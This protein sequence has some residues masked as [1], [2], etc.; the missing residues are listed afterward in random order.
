M[1]KY[2]SVD[3]LLMQEIDF[4]K[5]SAKLVKVNLAKNTILGS[6]RPI[7]ILSEQ[8]F[9]LPEPEVN[10]D[11]SGYESGGDDVESSDECFW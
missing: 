11:E 5:Y 1:M 7:N 2:F 10:Y 9:N 6:A 8:L 3:H 4:L